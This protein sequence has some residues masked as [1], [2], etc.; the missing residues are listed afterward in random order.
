MR[1]VDKEPKPLLLARCHIGIG[2]VES[3]RRR[4]ARKTA[5]ASCVE[6]AFAS[7][8]SPE[9]DSIDLDR[10]PSA[11]GSFDEQEVR[12]VELRYFAGLSISETAEALGVSPTAIKR[13]VRRSRL[14]LRTA[15]LKTPQEHSTRADL[16]CS[17]RRRFSPQ[18]TL[19]HR[20][21]W[22]PPARPGTDALRTESCGSSNRNDSHRTSTSARY[23]KL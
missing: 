5:P 16:L 23:R 14:A 4:H 6:E 18:S 8:M 1:T 9:V 20:S 10:A 22:S 21:R 19:L 2:T 17:A 11:L 7:A 12:I 3:W 13:V 15:P